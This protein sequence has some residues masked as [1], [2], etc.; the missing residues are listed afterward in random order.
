[1][2]S[3]AYKF[4]R[5]VIWG[6][7]FVFSSSGLAVGLASYWLGTSTALELRETS[8]E[9]LSLYQSNLLGELDKY[10]YLPFVLSGN[11]DVKDLIADLDRVFNLVKPGQGQQVAKAEVKQTQ[12]DTQQNASFK[13]TPAHTAL[14]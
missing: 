11:E 13:L 7:I 6:W 14:W 4:S 2:F 9:R 3:F 12:Q 10:R 8:I 1:M 5:Q